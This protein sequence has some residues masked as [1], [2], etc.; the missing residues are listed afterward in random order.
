VDR[1]FAFGEA[2]EAL[3]M[4]ETGSH[5]GKLVVRVVA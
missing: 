3:T 5:F 4:M 1:V 2:R